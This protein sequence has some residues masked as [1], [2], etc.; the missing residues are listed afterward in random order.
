MPSVFGCRFWEDF[1]CTSAFWVEAVYMAPEA[2]RTSVGGHTRHWARERSR[3]GI[4]PTIGRWHCSSPGLAAS[5]R[6]SSIVDFVENIYFPSIE[7]RLKPSTAKGYKD[8][9]RCHIEDRVTAIRVRDFRTVDG[10]NLMQNLER[11]HGRKLAHGTYKHIKVT[12]SAIF[13]E[14]KRKGLF[15]GV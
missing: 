11:D 5:E 14:A 3:L 12:L 7:K 8:A 13:T 1:F 15:D 2:H 4:V 9:W 10:E 6:R